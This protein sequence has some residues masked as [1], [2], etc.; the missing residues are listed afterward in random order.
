MKKTTQLIITL[1][2]ISIA[3]SAWTE[4]TNSRHLKVN[5][6]VKATEAV[7]G[8]RTNCHIE[9]DNAALERKTKGFRNFDF[10]SVLVTARCNLF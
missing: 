6:D 1:V 8:K 5:H 4:M 10:I 2:T 3:I 7:E 9:V